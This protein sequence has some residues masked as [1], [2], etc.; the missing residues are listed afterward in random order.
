[1]SLSE[2]YK[3]EIKGTFF[4]Q[5]QTFLD[6]LIKVYPEKR[7]LFED[8]MLYSSSKDQ[9]KFIKEFYIIINKYSKQL[10]AY[11]DDFLNEKGE[12]GKRKVVYLMRGIDF[13][14]LW[15]SPGI[16]DQI[17]KTMMA[18]LQLLHFLSNIYE[19]GNDETYQLYKAFKENASK[20]ESGETG[21][22]PLGNLMGGLG[23][24]GALNQEVEID[25]AKIEE[26][27][28]QIRKLMGK[29]QDSVFNDIISDMTK[30]IKSEVKGNTK[31]SLMDMLN[32]KSKLMENI[33]D[34]VRTNIDSKIKSGKLSEK[35]MM[36]SANNIVKNIT[37]NSG[38]NIDDMMKNISPEQVAEM[39]SMMK[40]V[41]NG[42]P[43]GLMN[44]MQS[45]MGNMNMGAK[46][47]K[48][49]KK[50]K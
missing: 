42:N 33:I 39:D 46:P 1:M 40:G 41:Q 30:A 3:N 5:L 23:G 44:M 21:G 36:N 48:N 19:N 47:K 35:D 15:T 10:L 2:E 14:E 6:E 24:L 17:R 32:G 37:G 50:K 8:Y 16:T 29:D 45:M 11:D 25:T 34:S 9:P 20:E 28:E 43:M 7:K 49:G 26:A 27:T 31:V 38:L 12:D 13:A 22:N 4:L 18:Y